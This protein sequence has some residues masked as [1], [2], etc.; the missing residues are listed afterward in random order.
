MGFPEPNPIWKCRKAERY[1]MRLYG[2]E[3]ENTTPEAAP[4][5]R[6]L[7][8]GEKILVGTLVAGGVGASIYCVHLAVNA[9]A[10]DAK[11]VGTG[12]KAG[13]N[14][15][16]ANKEERKKAIATLMAAGYTEEEAKALL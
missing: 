4:E 13:I 10:S 16:K 8:T 9:V 5:K 1:T 14:K 12:I 15:A 11:A 2:N 3:S 7:T 6:A